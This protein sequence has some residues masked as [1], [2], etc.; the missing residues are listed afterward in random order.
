MGLLQRLSVYLCA[1][2]M[3]TTTASVSVAAQEDPGAAQFR[4]SCGTCHTVD[5][6]APKRQGPHLWQVVG[7]ES[8]ALAA[9][10]Y[11]GA[12][13]AAGLVWNVE[14]LDRWISNAKKVVPGTTM[15]Y[16]QRNPEKRKLIIDYLISLGQPGEQ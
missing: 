1:A 10:D 4:K 15:A 13:A 6:K 2:V 3:V 8:G 11:S 7:R 9:Y 16:R 12:L 5:P 14:T